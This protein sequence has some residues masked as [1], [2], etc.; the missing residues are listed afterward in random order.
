MPAHALRSGTLARG[1]TAPDLRLPTSMTRAIIFKQ[2]PFFADIQMTLIV[3]KL[4]APCGAAPTV[5]PRLLRGLRLRR[6]DRGA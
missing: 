2:E 3:T 6:R 4:Q 5:H 1:E